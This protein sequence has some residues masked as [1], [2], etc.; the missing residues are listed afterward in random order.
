MVSKDKVVSMSYTLKD[1]EGKVLDASTEG[2]PLEF[3]HGHGNIIPGLEKALEGL[4]VG[5]KKNVDVPAA[6]GYGE[7]DADDVLRIGLDQLGGKVPPV[8][9]AIELRSDQGD[10][11]VGLVTAITASEMVVDCNHPLAGKKLHF[12]V[13]IVALRDATAEEL[14]HGHAHGPEGHGH[15]HAHGG[16]CGDNDQ[17]DEGG[18]CGGGC[19]CDDE[20]DDCCGGDCGCDDDCEHDHSDG[21][22]CDEDHDHDDCCKKHDHHE[23]GCC[24]EH[25]H[26]DS[27]CCDAHGHDHS[28]CCGEHDHKDGDCCQ[29]K[30]ES[31]CSHEHGDECKHDHGHGGCCKAEHAH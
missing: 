12:D 14:E 5:D 21:S 4:K 9:V 30:D 26:K 7:Y 6:E 25:T 23:G 24:A 18:C 28:D 11:M 16:C 15:H 22:C 1:D 2:N 20:E 17:D 10:V 31:C 13:E 29:H 27:G 3:L 19:G 8:G